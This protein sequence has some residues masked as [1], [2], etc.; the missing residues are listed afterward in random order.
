MLNACTCSQNRKNDDYSGVQVQLVAATEID[1]V[2]EIGCS[3]QRLFII[4]IVSVC[5][6]LGLTYVKTVNTCIWKFLWSAHSTA[7]SM[8]RDGSENLSTAKKCG[9][10]LCY[11]LFVF[12]F[13][14][15]LLFFYSNQV[16]QQSERSHKINT[17][18]YINKAINR[19][20]TEACR[21]HLYLWRIGV[22]EKFSFA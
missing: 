1:Q 5:M 11:W 6:H 16:S 19:W 14:V 12:P 8:M 22:L 15:G 10:V 9:T 7:S 21:K 4:R 3:N 18:E 17:F 2:Q 13:F 20:F